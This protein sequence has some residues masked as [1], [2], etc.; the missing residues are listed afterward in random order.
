MPLA[1]LVTFLG[2][3]TTETL[4]LCLQAAVRG[5]LER[6]RY[7]RLRRLTIGLQAQCRGWAA[8][9]HHRNL[10]RQ[11]AALIIQT[12]VRGWLQRR[13]YRATL[14]KIIMVQGAV[15]RHYARK[16][17]KKLKIEAKSVHKQ[18][19]LNKGLEI[20]IMSLQQRI[21]EMK[22]DNKELRVKVEKGVGLSEELEK[23]K[24]TEEES[25]AR[26]GKIKD[27]EEELRKVKADLQKE[28]D[29]KVDLVT[30]KVKSEEDWAKAEAVLKEE[31]MKLKSE[32]ENSLKIQESSS[33]INRKF[34][35]SFTLSD[36]LFILVHPI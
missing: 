6:S 35:P 36:L 31:V 30:E 13:R 20:K 34:S 32:L 24:K 8:R 15:R 25:K 3:N 23:M 11:R 4:N 9:R 18:K 27:L 21:N 26:G 14:K 2:L 16:E 29:E 12:R 22:E 19:E 33:Q 28:R 17:F 10:R 5:W 7:T 1:L